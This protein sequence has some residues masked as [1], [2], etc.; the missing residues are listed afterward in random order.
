M[1]LCGFAGAVALDLA[2]YGPGTGPILLDNVRCYGT[3]PSLFKCDHNGFGHH[4]CSHYEDAGVM[5]QGNILCICTI[6]HPVAMNV[7]QNI[8][9][10]NNYF[11][12]SFLL[13]AK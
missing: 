3:E 5:C 9:D 10:I 11:V 7:I 2:H 4:D 1:F 12:H 13:A 8:S 6:V